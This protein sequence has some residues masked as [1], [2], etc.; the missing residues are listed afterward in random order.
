MSD[1]PALGL[2]IGL[3]KTGTTSLQEL[4][5]A[6]H[7]QLA[8]Y[9]QTNL[10]DNPDAKS[11]LRALLLDDEPADA[12]R[13]ALQRGFAERDAVMISDEALSMGEFMLRATRWPV[14][15][16]HARTA[17][18]ARALLGDAHVFL[19]LRNQADWLESWHRQGLKTGKYA[20]TGFARWL[21]RDL[22]SAAE[23]LYELL[24]YDRLYE[25]WAGAFGPDRVHVSLYEEQGPR[26][27][28]LAAMTVESLGAD[29][30][31]ARTL[32]AAEPRNVTGTEFRGLPPLVQHLAR[33]GP[34]RR[35]LQAIP[36]RPRQVIRGLIER[37]RA[38][39]G[40]E[41]TDKDAIRQHFAAS[42]AALFRELGMDGRGFGY[43]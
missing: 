21:E 17:G 35:I 8:Y 13:A 37:R 23:R 25:A 42:N 34:G 20:E 31:R 43:M 39:A 38:Y 28:D 3:P 29:G 16:D 24:R 40:I 41:Q 7:P 11:L 36:G 6:R 9:G 30:Q 5:F 14:H 19:V 33:S 10:W 27:P 1:G 15:S 32:A 18:R 2:H 26:F 4:V 12:A 22:G